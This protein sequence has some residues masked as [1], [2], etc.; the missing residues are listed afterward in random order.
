M[1]KKK[2]NKLTSEELKSVHEQQT[3][4]NNILHEIGVLETKK[5][6]LLHDVAVTNEDINNY[7]KHLEEKYG[8]ISIDLSDGSFTKIDETPNV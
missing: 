2:V 3:K 5:H 6:A 1:S 7:K 4:T 8:S